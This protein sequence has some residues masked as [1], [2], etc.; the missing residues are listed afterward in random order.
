MGKDGPSKSMGAKATI[1]LAEK[2]LKSKPG[3]G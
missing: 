2:E 1:D 3:P